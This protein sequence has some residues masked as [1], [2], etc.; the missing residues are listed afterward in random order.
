MDSLIKLL[1]DKPELS[2]FLTL[3]LG[4]YLG[5]L[6]LGK[7]GFGTVVGTLIVGLVVGIF[8]K[9]QYPDLIRWSFFYLFLFGVGYGVGPQFFASLRKD[10]LPLV[11]LAVVICVSGLVATLGMCLLF[12]FDVGTA[13]GLLSGGLTQSA[14][15]G[16]GLGAINELPLDEATRTAFAANAPL[17]DAITYGFGDLGLILWLTVFGPWLIKA[18]LRK[19]C[20]LLAAKMA[21]AEGPGALLTP[22][23]FSFRAY[24]ITAMGL[25][26]RTTGELE[27]QFSAYRLSIQRVMRGGHALDLRPDLSLDHS[28]TI[29]I[30]AKSSLFAEAAGK[31]GPEV[32]DP[33]VLNVP[34]ATGAVI[35]KSKNVVRHSF[36][37]LVADPA[38]LEASRGVFV[39]SLRR[40]AE[41]L[42][43]TPATVIEAGDVIHLIGSRNDIDRATELIGFKEYD[44]EKANIALI[45]GA[46]AL[47]VLLGFL[48]FKVGGVPI[49][50]G[51]CGSILLVGLVAGWLRG[52]TPVF[53][54][55]PEPARRLLTD[56]G[57]IVF[58][59]IIGLNAGPHAVDALHERGVPYFMKVFGAGVVVTMAG[60]LIGTLFAHWVLKMNPVLILGG[61][62]G[63][64]TCTPGLNALR[65]EGGSNVAA[66][67]YPVT[68]AIGNVLLTVWGP[69]VV[70]IVHAWNS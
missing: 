38:V 61:V 12:H 46:I 4:Q 8:A 66:L 42:P 17:G 1:H 37:E 49:G 65:E 6:K 18:D 39:Q 57:L 25:P 7:F 2:L 50:L 51:A 60:P 27:K 58:I 70:A 33:A 55:V 44:S 22:P 43:L 35:V 29:V 14:A 41:Q 15:L 34:L 13:V 20:E 45:A 23:S 16:T 54:A 5:R 21:G 67:G 64:Q 59:A 10:T 62:T 19:E 24:R 52:R 63:A 30:A 3:M 32:T 69:V 56:I 40:G 47:G 28:D 68:Y 9:P 53:G 31:I 48:S 11:A 26:G 36:A